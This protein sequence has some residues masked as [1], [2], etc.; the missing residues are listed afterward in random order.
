[1]K[2]R[3]TRGCFVDLGS[4][5]FGLLVLAACVLVG[6]N[7]QSQV[8]SPELETS[9]VSNEAEDQAALPPVVLDTLESVAVDALANDLA[10]S[11]NEEFGIVEK[12]VSEAKSL[13]SDESVLESLQASLEAYKNAAGNAEDNIAGIDAEMME[14]VKKAAEGDVEAGK[15]LLKRSPEVV[16]VMEDT[17]QGI[18]RAKSARDDVLKELNKVSEVV[19]CDSVEQAKEVM[20]DES[21]WDE[22]LKVLDFLL[23]ILTFILT[24]WGSGDNSGGGEA[25]VDGTGEAVAAL[26]GPAKHV[27]SMFRSNRDADSHD[28]ESKDTGS[29]ATSVVSTDDS[30][31]GIVVD[32]EGKNRTVEVRSQEVNAPSARVSFYLGE[33]DPAFQE[34]L[35]RGR[36]KLQVVQSD[37]YLCL[38]ATGLPDDVARLIAWQAA[39]SPAVIRAN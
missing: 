25:G 28:A 38:Q 13:V 27:A 11:V 20:E 3:L 39:D 23:K 10:E 22:V 12:A 7:S 1:M 4:Q 36:L 5:S 16:S 2:S 8:N 37:D 17:K 29:E 30:T 24:I 18:E 19:D 35:S 26:V 14:L 31:Y 21:F 15:E 34:A 32:G 6:C 33:Q 9:R